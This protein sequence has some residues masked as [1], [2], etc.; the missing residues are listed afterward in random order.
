MNN[1]ALIKDGKVINVIVADWQNVNK[2]AKL[3]ECEFVNVDFYP[4]QI[5]DDYTDGVFYRDGVEI[6]RI[7]T[8]SEKIGQ[9]ESDVISAQQTIT[10]LD[11]ADIVSEQTIT[12]LDLRI[13]ESEVGV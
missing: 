8:D 11:L 9:L 12:D 4:V 5:G 6:K 10:D 3:Q 7:K 2:I 13:L 1:Y